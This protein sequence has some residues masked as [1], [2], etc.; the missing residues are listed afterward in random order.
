MWFSKMSEKAVL[1]ET[2]SNSLKQCALA[3][4]ELSPRY[5]LLRSIAKNIYP[6]ALLNEIRLIA[7]QLQRTDG[8][9]HISEANVRIAESIQNELIPFIFERIGDKFSYIFI[10]EFQDTS[11]LQWQNLLPIVVEAISSQTF[12]NES[13]KAILFG[14][15][16]QAIYRF[17]GGD[18]GQFSALPQVEGVP[19]NDI[20][21]EREE[22]LVRNFH[23]NHLATNWRSKKEIIDFNN[24]FFEAK[25]LNCQEPQIKEIYQSVK[26]QTPDNEKV[27]GGVFMSYLRKTE[28]KSDYKEFIF[29]EIFTII[30]TALQDNYALADIAILVRGNDL[31]TAIAKQLSEQK[32]P[33]ISAESLL[34]A[35]NREVIFLI[36]CLSYLT[37]ANN[38]IAKANILNFI[39]LQKN[40]V[41]EEI[42]PYS[43]DEKSFIQFVQSEYQQF[44]PFGLQ[45]Q[46]LYERIENLIRIFNLAEKAN[47]FILAFLDFAADFTNMAAKSQVQFLDYWKEKGGKLSLSN[48][49]GIDAVTVM[50]IHQSKGLEFPIVIYPCKEPRGGASSKW[51]D[52][53][54]PIGKL[55]AALLQVADMRNTCFEPLYTEEKQLEKLDALNIDYVAFT[56]AEDRLYLLGK[57]D[58]KRIEEV[59]D[60]FKNQQIEPTVSAD[61]R[62][63]YYQYGSKTAKPTTSKTKEPKTV[64]GI[65]RYLSMP[66]SVRFS[67]KNLPAAGR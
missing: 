56:R 54:E 42:L 63:D 61:E 43:T 13:G 5:A 20:I 57:E 35:N 45:K 39:A 66:L 44:N 26:Q 50:T 58:D 21:Q 40:L 30:Q 17:R 33:T 62:I 1:V 18:V 12:E 52:L 28:E 36:A 32:I 8:V 38:P 53:E 51:V 16:K 14:D 46:N 60:F 67:T 59:L 23:K 27:G 3:I 31:G 64:N 11:V 9:M 48:P 7:A 24:A 34:L 25:T 15:A 41:K 29:N 37:N 55:N 10:D 65:K 47:P 6:V 2:I 4:I 49:K 19:K 22:A